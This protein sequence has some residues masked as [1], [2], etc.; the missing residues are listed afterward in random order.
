LTSACDAYVKRA[1]HSLHPPHLQLVQ[2]TA[3]VGSPA[4][5]YRA[6]L[7]SLWPMPQAC[8]R[9]STNAHLLAGMSHAAHPPAALRL[10]AARTLDR[11][12]CARMLPPHSAPVDRVEADGAPSVRRPIGSG[13]PN[14][15]PQTALVTATPRP[16]TY[17]ARRAT[18]RVTRAGRALQRT[19]KQQVNSWPWRR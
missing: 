6:M 15:A 17:D 1:G 14:S 11:V 7:V 3:A 8:G 2:S 12:G 16:S 18:C 13:G 9:L 10:L 5:A 19:S 4:Q